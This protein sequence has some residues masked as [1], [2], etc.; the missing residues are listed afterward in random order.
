MLKLIVGGLYGHVGANGTSK[1]VAAFDLDGTL[2]RTIHSDPILT[3]PTQEPAAT[4][5]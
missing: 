3:I 4:L 1:Y 5:I 2:I